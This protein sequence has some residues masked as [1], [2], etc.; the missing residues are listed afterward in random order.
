MKRF[1]SL[2]LSAAL[3]LGLLAGC[4]LQ[5]GIESS[6]PA[7]SEEPA[8][9][10]PV[11]AD[12]SCGLV[13][14]GTWSALGISIPN[15]ETLYGDSDAQPADL[16]RLAAYIEGAYGL[17]GDEWE[18]AAVARA[19]GAS[20]V[21]LS[22]LRFADEEGA[23]HG[24]ACLKE[25]LHS[26]EGDFAGYSPEQARLAAD[27]AVCRQGRYVGLFIVKDSGRAQSVFSDIIQTGRLPDLSDP[28]PTPELVKDA[29]EIL[30]R[31][32]EYCGVLGDNTSDLERVDRSDLDKLNSIMDEYGLTDYPW[33]D[34]AVARGTGGNVFEIA[35][36]HI[37]GD[38]RTGMDAVT[39]LNAYLDAKEDACSHLPARAVLLHNAMAV[40]SDGFI[41]LLVCNEPETLAPELG[42]ILG[43]GSYSTMRRHQGTNPTPSAELDPGDLDRFKF[44]PPN[45]ED[46]S[47][48][49]TSA[50]RSAWE[51]GDPAALSDYDRAVY[52]G[53]KKVLDEILKD[54][55]SDLEKE[56][57]I[58]SWIVNHVDYD[59]RHQDVMAETPR[60]S[61]TPYGT[62]V[63]HTAVC[64][65]YATAFQLLC[66]LAG[67]ECITVVG[68]AHLSEEDHG[69]NMVRLNGKWYCVDVT[70][71]ANFREQG[72]SSGEQKEWRWFNVTSDRMA[73]TDHQWD[74][75]NVPEAVTGGNGLG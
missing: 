71:D 40:W 59:W 68:A 26:R 50:I 42:R 54:G 38:L 20:A 75:A 73:Q 4:N 46:M 63:E 2:L 13:L 41:A 60:E 33:T 51:K 19:T 32:V 65:G 30:N 3:L 53:A 1:A 57:A 47:L 58:Y 36:L 28:T 29:A 62:L 70:W 22:V 10:G 66:D 11:E 35:V 8:G 27:G 43:N 56:T 52:D 34:A 48:Y 74:Y 16:E 17:S 69:W 6:R 23:R 21:E 25:Y 55:M 37:D 45:K 12:L 44:T 72:A 49:D 64:L 24:E 39:A 61:Y 31:Y 67:V 9:S 7:G 15:A 14:N 5:E 18:D